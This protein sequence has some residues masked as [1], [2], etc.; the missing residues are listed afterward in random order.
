MLKIL[1]NTHAFSTYPSQMD[2]CFSEKCNLNCQYCFV[3]KTNPYN[4]DFLFVKKA[5][6]IFLSFP[7]E[8]KTITFTTGEPLLNKKLFKRSIDYILRESK[9]RKINLYLVATTNGTLMDEDMLEFFNERLGNNFVLNISLDGNKKSND[10]YRKFK[11][12]P[13]KSIFDS[14]W[15]YF[16]MLP[17][18]KVRVI[19]TI[20][21]SETL[22]LKENV[23]FLL[24]N[25]FKNID[26]FP[27]MLT[28]WPKN[29]L[30]ELFNGIYWAVTWFNKNQKGY[31]LRLLNRLW[32]SSHYEEILFASDANFYLFE[33]VLPLPHNARKKYIIGDADNGVNFF[34]RQVLFDQLFNKIKK[35]SKY[36][37]LKCEYQVFCA[38]PIPLY[39]WCSYYKKD[40]NKYLDNFCQ[41]S[42]NFINL[43]KK[44][45]VKSETD[46]EKWIKY[47]IEK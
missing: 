21:P 19:F 24:E 39:L 47:G 6:D 18:E 32:G 11:F 43:S 22:R 38:N 30:K 12:F 46:K 28:L 45:N 7:G 37:C 29:K 1:K 40:F 2:I 31:N 17:K 14:T 42:R 20:T 26:L 5:V 35:K 36:K 16:Q 9:K 23:K 4:L 3:K 15:K 8:E 10:A 13:N 44:L 34:K 27:Q 33:W 25:G 41:I